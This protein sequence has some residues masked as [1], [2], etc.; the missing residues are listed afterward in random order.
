M[1][2]KWGHP[3][4]TLPN[5]GGDYTSLSQNDVNSA[6]HRLRARGGVDGDEMLRNDRKRAV[7]ATLLVTQASAADRT[8]QL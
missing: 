2:Y 8:T 3:V 1:M 7:Y 6:N 5:D 4:A